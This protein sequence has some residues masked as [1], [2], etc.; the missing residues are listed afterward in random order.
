VDQPPVQPSEY[1]PTVEDLNEIAQFIR[2]RSL[3]EAQ[4]AGMMQ[5]NRAHGVTIRVSLPKDM[6]PAVRDDTR[7][8]VTGWLEEHSPDRF[9]D[10]ASQ[11]AWLAYNLASE[12]VDNVHTHQPHRPGSHRVRS[13]WRALVSAARLWETHPDFKPLWAK[14]ED[15]QT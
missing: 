14:D 6:V 13:A 15:A 4:A 7:K 9:M 8:A 1:E 10:M 11:L 3:Q 5:S 2:Q 12:A